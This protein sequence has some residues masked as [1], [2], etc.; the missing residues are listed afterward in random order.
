MIIT[1]IRWAGCCCTCWLATGGGKE[2]LLDMLEEEPMFVALGH[3]MEFGCG[4]GG[5]SDNRFAGCDCRRSCCLDW[6]G[7]ERNC[8]LWLLVVL[9]T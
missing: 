2:Q 7:N 9:R 5:L 1:T 4:F 6:T 8:G 3:D